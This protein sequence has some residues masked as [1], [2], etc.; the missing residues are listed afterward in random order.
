MSSWYNNCDGNLL[1]PDPHQ[2]KVDRNTIFHLFA[3]SLPRGADV[4]EIG[5]ALIQKVCSI[6]EKQRCRNIG[7]TNVWQN[8]EY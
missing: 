8:N 2:V 6:Q 3:E 4:T 1:Q 7:H 5:K